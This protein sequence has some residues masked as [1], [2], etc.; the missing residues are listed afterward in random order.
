MA[1]DRAYAKRVALLAALLFLVALT[2]S[3]ITLVLHEFAGHGGVAAVLGSTVDSYELFLFAGGHIRSVRAEPFTQVENISIALG[4]IAVQVLL[5]VIALLLARRCRRGS[6][7]HIALHGYAGVVIIHGLFYLAAGTY[8]GYGDGWSLHRALGAE[9]VYFAFPIALA[10]VAI[11]YVATRHLVSILRSR[12]SG[13]SRGAQLAAVLVAGAIAAGG[14]G[15]LAFGELALRPDRTYQQVMT[16][17]YE[18]DVRAALY[19]YMKQQEHSGLVVTEADVAKQRRTLVKKHKPFPLNHVL[20]FLVG[21][22]FL[23]AAIRSRQRDDI[24]APPVELRDLRWIAT[25]CGASLAVV[26]TIKWIV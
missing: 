14:H 1:M 4:G 2:T 7:A 17:Q 3:R 15:A 18:Y 22:A 10:V 6:I 23:A 16:H 8:H 24:D 9:R 25:A 20:G 12:L 11:A 19:E 13:D 5:G 26:A 21:I